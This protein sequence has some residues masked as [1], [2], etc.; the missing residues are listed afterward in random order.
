MTYPSKTASP[1]K[2]SL[3]SAIVNNEYNSSLLS[4]KTEEHIQAIQSSSK[5]TDS[6]LPMQS[7]PITSFLMSTSV[8]KTPSLDSTASSETFAYSGHLKTV[9]HR[10]QSSLQISLPISFG[11]NT[12]LTSS[13]LPVQTVQTTAFVVLRNITPPDSSYAL[14][15][16]SLTLA[17]TTQSSKDASGLNTIDLTTIDTNY[18]SFQLSSTVEDNYTLTIRSTTSTSLLAETNANKSLSQPSPFR[19]IPSSND[20]Y[21][22]PI[23]KEHNSTLSEFVVKKNVTPTI[24]SIQ[25]TATTAAALSSFSDSTMEKRNPSSQQTRVLTIFTSFASS[26]TLLVSMSTSPPNQIKSFSKEPNIPS[27]LTT[28]LSNKAVESIQLI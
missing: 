3:G 9:R 22:Q 7:S 1:S 18:N 25:I 24:Q 23:H 8:M 21:P 20:T 11:S 27:V 17:V 19:T 4:Y 13:I 14:T 12:S 5:D 2:E 15:E 16:K 10:N 26:L 6:L 28:A